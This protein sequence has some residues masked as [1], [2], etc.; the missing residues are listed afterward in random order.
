MPSVSHSQAIQT[1]NPFYAQTASIGDYIVTT[2]PLGLSRSKEKHLKFI[3]KLKE[4]L[5]LA[6]NQ[7]A[8]AM[9]D[10]SDG[11]A[12]DLRRIMTESQ[13]PSCQL[14]VKKIPLSSG[15]N[16]ENDADIKTALTEG[17]DFELLFT[18]S[19]R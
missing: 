15:L 18:L 11:L 10:I 13:L 14:D 8:T 1:N 7:L 5:F 4:G 17:E 2:G 3:P 16:A 9:M 6:E 19:S 12:S